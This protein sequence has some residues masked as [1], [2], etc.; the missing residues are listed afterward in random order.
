MF[1]SLTTQYM[2]Q[3]N[4]AEMEW[5]CAVGRGTE[6]LQ[7]QESSIRE[8]YES[9]KSSM[10]RMGHSIRKQQVGGLEEV[11]EERPTKEHKA[12]VDG[13]SGKSRPKVRRTEEVNEL[14]SKEKA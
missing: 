7:H 8:K 9:R 5:N 6:E 4:R 1:Q 13:T 12:E 2:C 11:G 14:V 10:K 3:V